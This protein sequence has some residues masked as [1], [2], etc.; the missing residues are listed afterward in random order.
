[1]N[2]MEERQRLGSK[3]QRQVESTDIKFFYKNVYNLH[4]LKGALFE[5]VIVTRTLEMSHMEEMS[6]I[7][8]FYSL[9]W[10]SFPL[11]Y[12]SAAITA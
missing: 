7:I 1:M 8:F 4:A 12:R 2:L 5:K 6:L 10:R 9:V 3:Q 11:N